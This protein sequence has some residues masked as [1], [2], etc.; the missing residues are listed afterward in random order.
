MC[1]EVAGTTPRSI[2]NNDLSIKDNQNFLYRSFHAII[3]ETKRSYNRI[4]FITDFQEKNDGSFS[5]A[6][7]IIKFYEGWHN[8][9]LE[10]SASINNNNNN[11][12][13]NNIAPAD[14]ASSDFNIDVPRVCRLLLVTCIPLAHLY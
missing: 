9:L 13:I 8:I 1:P 6:K 11:N 2:N 12:D 14:I 3:P 4:T 10:V 5:K 7:K